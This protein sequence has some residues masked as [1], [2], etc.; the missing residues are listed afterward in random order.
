MYGRIITLEDLEK[1]LKHLEML[2]IDVMREINNMKLNQKESIYYDLKPEQAHPL[3]R[4]SHE[5]IENIPYFQFSYDGM[6]PHF[7]EKDN[8][9]LS[10]VRNYYLRATLDSYNFKKVDYVFGEAVIVFAQ[11][12]KDDIIRDLENRNKK[13]IQDAIKATGLIRDDHWSAVWN[14][15]VGFSDTESNHVQVYLVSKEDFANFYNI[16]L[17]KHDEMKRTFNIKEQ[18]E[19]IL[20][21]IKNQNQVKN[22]MSYKQNKTNSFD[23]LF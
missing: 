22:E 15:D 1:T 11:Y 18:K 23:V 3:S 20:S 5:I 21:E 10:M 16:L 2:R 8:E 7:N 13:Y 6:L 12:F 9:Y 4:V 14:V 17:E 19:N